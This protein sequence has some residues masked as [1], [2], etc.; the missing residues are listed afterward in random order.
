[1]TVL[2]PEALTNFMLVEERG[3]QWSPDPVVV[4]G[5]IS[6]TDLTI[7]TNVSG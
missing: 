6:G 2:N 1:V 4:F 5:H 7:A 3:T